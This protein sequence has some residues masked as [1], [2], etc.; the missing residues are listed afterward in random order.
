MNFDIPWGQK[1]DL[2]KMDFCSAFFLLS[3]GYY[4]MVMTLRKN[5]FDEEENAVLFSISF[6]LLFELLKKKSMKAGRKMKRLV[7]KRRFRN[8]A[9]ISIGNHNTGFEVFG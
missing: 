8:C 1:L 3:Y 2:R 4:M 7:S 9:T 5:T 6:L